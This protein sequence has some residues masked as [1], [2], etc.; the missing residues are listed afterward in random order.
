[1]Q[2]MYDTIKEYGWIQGLGLS[3]PAIFGVGVQTYKGRPIDELSIKIRDGEATIEDIKQ[4][5]KDGLIKNNTQAV[6]DFIETAKLPNDIYNFKKRTAKEQVE[7]LS[8]MDKD[9]ILK[10][11][12]YV[13]SNFEEA[14]KEYLEE[15]K[16]EDSI[17][18]NISEGEASD[19]GLIHT[20][21]LY[22][23]AIKTDPLTA[24]NRIFTGQKIRRIDSD[25]I[26]VERMPFEESQSIRQERGVVGD[27]VLDHIIPLVLGGSNSENNLKL[28]PYDE[29]KSYTPVETY[30]GRLLQNGEIT[31]KE[32]QK[33]IQD[34]KNGKI[35]ADK[36]M[37]L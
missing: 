3:L 37:N 5:V 26:I 33:L 22:A 28:V 11:L 20:I 34:F 17:K 12:P 1:M 21:V 9:D 27:M 16:K 30:L 24:F 29:W 23:N 4:A 32:A 8:G 14:F 2:D 35:S 7:F 19:K 10:Y 6:T 36:I 15:R 31:K 25:T 18:P 13:K